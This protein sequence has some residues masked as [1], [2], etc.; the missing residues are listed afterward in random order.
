L[1]SEALKPET[2]PGQLYEEL[3]VLYIQTLKE[4]VAT[5]DNVGPMYEALH[6][7]N[8]P[9]DLSIFDEWEK[10]KAAIEQSRARPS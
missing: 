1:R 9:I 2:S 7:P 5:P 10:K 6:M 4:C 8:E 3:V